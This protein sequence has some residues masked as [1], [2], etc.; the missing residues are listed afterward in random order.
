LIVHNNVRSITGG[1][2]INL[3]VS[4]NT[5]FINGN[6]SISGI[7]NLAST[8]SSLQPALISDNTLGANALLNGNTIKSISAAGNYL[9]FTFPNQNTVQLVTNNIQSTLTANGNDTTSFKLLNVAN[10]T[11]RSIQAGAGIT[12]TKM[13]IM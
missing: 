7:T 5:I 8:L 13:L 4:N 6:N 10:N 2:N 11:I 9:S 1:T 12:I 3:N